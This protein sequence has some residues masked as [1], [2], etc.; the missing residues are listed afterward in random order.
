MGNTLHA[1]SQRQSGIA[2]EVGVAFY[3]EI[4]T[5]LGGS[6]Q[7]CI[8][9]SFA[10]GSNPLSFYIPFLAGEAPLSYTL[11]RQMPSRLGHY[12]ENHL[13]NIL[14]TFVVNI[15][16]LSSSFSTRSLFITTRNIL[17]EWIC[18]WKVHDITDVL[19]FYSFSCDPFLWW[20]IECAKPLVT[21]FTKNSWYVLKIWKA[22]PYIACSRC[23]DSGGGAKKSV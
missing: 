21:H 4:S 16:Y 11:Y 9:G 18:L 8:R 17:R 12:R 2:L 22:R 19:F 6:Q 10:L 13:G 1:D 5:P 23:S 15:N 20:M 7:R 14:T 3:Y